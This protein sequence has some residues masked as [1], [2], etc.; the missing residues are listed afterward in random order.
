[1]FL[2]CHDLSQVHRNGDF[3]DEGDGKKGDIIML[4]NGDDDGKPSKE[5]QKSRAGNSGPD[6][7]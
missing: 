6:R 5:R 3:G 2:L 1:M 4:V 7:Y